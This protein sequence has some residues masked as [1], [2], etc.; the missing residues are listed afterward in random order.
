MTSKLVLK[1]VVH[2]EEKRVLFAEADSNFVDTLFSIMTLPMATVVR[3]LRNCSDNKLKVIGSL[4]NLYNSLS[5]LPDKCLSTEGIKQ[6]LLNTR[7]SAHDYCI[8]LKLNIDDAECTKYYV[9][10]DW[11]CSR[12]SG[13][14]FSTIACVRCNLCGKAMNRICQYEELTAA[15]TG[16]HYDV[17]VFVSDVTTF[18]VT[19]DLRV[20]PNTSGN[21]IQLLSALGITDT[22]QI[23]NMNFDIGLNQVILCV[24]Q[25][26]HF[27]VLYKVDN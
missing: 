17:G 21:I 12:R 3:H 1:L 5:N 10:E 9:C 13:A 8:K 16:N 22:S 14:N 18:I 15:P 25:F 7:T 24:F 11:D 4:N 19:D 27:Y 20:M 2:K 26:N 6:T 23:A